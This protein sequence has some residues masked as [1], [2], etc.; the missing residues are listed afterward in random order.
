MKRRRFLKAAA[1]SALTFG[2]VDVADAATSGIRTSQERGGK[3]SAVPRRELGATGVKVPILQLGCSQRLDSRYDKVMHLCFR[4]GVDGLDTALSYGW[5]ASHRAIANFI[6]Q[7]GERKRLFITSKSDSSS[8]R[9]IVDDVDECLDELKTDYL[10]LYLMHQIY[11]T[12]MLE[13]RYIQAGDTLRK[14]GKTKF[15]GFSCHGGN[16]V[17]LMN[18]AARTGG[19]DAILFSYNFRYY[20]DLEL[21]RAIDACKN[22]GIGLI[23]MK[24]Y[25][26]VPEDAEK[27][28]QFT[29]ENF[30]LAQAKLKSVWADERI[31]TVLSEM[32]SVRV[33]RENIEAAK[34]EKSLSAA[35]VHQLNRLAAL[36][37]HLYCRGCSHL[38][39]MHLKGRT[40]VADSLRFLMYHESYRK[41]NRARELYQGRPPES[42]NFNIA[43]ATKASTFCPQGIDIAARLEKARQELGA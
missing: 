24:T 23:A 22:A 33:A 21:N 34:S 27:V 42:W 6:G 18:R 9:R 15:F 8:P 14:S 1:A 17:E 43:E 41:T 39:E 16:V 5:G 30:T 35:E 20:G 38:C 10:D 40:R 36:T 31:D 13:K 26:A 19:I 29:S 11:D 3:R 32:D 37:S 12:S 28:I 25:G 4:E 2:L 7:V